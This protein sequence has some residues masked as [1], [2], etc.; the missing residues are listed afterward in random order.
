[1]ARPFLVYFDFMKF[2]KRIWSNEFY[3]GGIIFTLASFVT[4][5]MNYLF[6][7]F[8][9]RGLGPSGYGEITTMF[10]YIAISSTPLA[11]LTTTIIQK[12]GSATNQISYSYALEQWF[13]GKLKNFLRRSRTFV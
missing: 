6:N 3:Q 12:I 11:V 8:A 7:V 13:F 2:I 1:M 4:S 10:S 9:A 5:F